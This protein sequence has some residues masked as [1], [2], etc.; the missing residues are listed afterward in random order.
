MKFGLKP[1]LGLPM[2]QWLTVCLPTQGTQFRYLGQGVSTCQEQLRLFVTAT[3]A[4]V[5]RALQHEK[6]PQQEGHAAQ[7]ERP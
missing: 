1:K 7:T 6:P 4:P 5:P 3:E 2:A